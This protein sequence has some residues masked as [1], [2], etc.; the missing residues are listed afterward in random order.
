MHSRSAAV[1]K[2]SGDTAGNVNLIRI[3][4]CTRSAAH[5]DLPPEEQQRVGRDG[6][7]VPQVD[8]ARP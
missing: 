3:P 5:L 8:R 7:G 4:L 2:A 1:S 6:H